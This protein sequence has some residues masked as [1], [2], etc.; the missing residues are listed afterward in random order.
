VESFLKKIK[1]EASSAGFLK[2]LFDSDADD[3]GDD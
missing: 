1:A 3:E 2:S